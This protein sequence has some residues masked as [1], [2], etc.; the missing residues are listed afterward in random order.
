MAKEVQVLFDNTDTNYKNYREYYLEWC[1]IN[2]MEPQ[3]DIPY[4]WIADVIQMDW[5]DTLDNIKH[6]KQ[7]GD[8]VII[9]TLGLWNGRHDV[10]PTRC[11]SLDIAIQKCVGSCEYARVT[12]SGGIINV[13]A[14]HHDG[15]NRFEIHLLNK[16]AENVKNEDKLVKE[17]YHKKIKGYL[18]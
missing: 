5:N 8:C 3:E 6:S 12:L 17:Y 11:N 14:I 9:G 7:N 2:N 15:T 16:R 13:S 18:F 10:Y 4:D 1:E